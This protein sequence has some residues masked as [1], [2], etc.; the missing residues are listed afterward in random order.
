M[1][2]NDWAERS[3][4]IIEM[5]NGQWTLNQYGIDNDDIAPTTAKKTKEEIVARLMQVMDIKTAIKPQDFPE[6]ICV[7]FI[8]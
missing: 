3:Q 4:L 8:Q 1:T 7:E 6:E 2:L 5:K